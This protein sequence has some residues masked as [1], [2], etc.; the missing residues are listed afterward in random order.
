MKVAAIASLAVLSCFA[1][2]DQQ[3]D[4]NWTIEFE[5][6][7][8][9]TR[10]NYAQ[11]PNP[12][13]SIVNLRDLFGGNGNIVGRT[14]LIYSTPNG[15]QWKLLY[16]PL[17]IKGTGTLTGPTQYGGQAFSPGSVDGLYQF[18]SYRLTY[19]KQWR[20]N[21]FLGG[22][23]KIRDAEIK[24][25]QGGTVAEEKNVGF[26]P[27]L[28]IYGFGQISRDLGYEIELD[29]LAGGPGRAFDLS[30]RATKQLDSRTQAFLGLRVLEGG[31]DVPRVKNF[32]WVNYLTAGISY[33]F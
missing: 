32:A 27:L 1:V 26:V 33:R 31:A 11:V 6:G 13:G 21:W 28:N 8:I 30:M 22:T 9:S 4:K 25:T 12:G 19:R 29:G 2:A 3:N 7:S 5:L 16:A 18:N 23:L 15:A 20:G 24:L 14:S 17:R 10:Y